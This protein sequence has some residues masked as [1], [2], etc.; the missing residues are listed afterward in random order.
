MDGQFITLLVGG[1]LLVAFFFLYK[2]NTK[3][4]DRIAGPKRRVSYECVVTPA[5]QADE[6]LSQHF[7]ELSE[8][9]SRDG[10]EL[11]RLGVFNWGEL[12]L[13][14]DHIQEPIT[15]RFAQSTEI[16]SITPGET[17]KTE[18]D[19]PE[20]PQAAGSV[21][22]FPAFAIAPRGTIIFNVM[23]RGAGKPDSVTGLIEGCGQIRRLG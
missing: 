8:H 22:T 16:L 4:A 18:L 3:T 9:P 2:S 15:V 10:I 6:E 14:V 23:V 1:I 17:F 7:P 12:E 11:I 21:L 19:M 5:H 20:P 13:E